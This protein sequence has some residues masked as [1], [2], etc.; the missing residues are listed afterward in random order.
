MARR[1]TLLAS[2]LIVA[3][4]GLGTAASLRDPLATQ[5]FVLLSAAVQAAA[6]LLVLEFLLDAARPRARA[7]GSPDR[8][9]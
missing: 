3:L 6:G 9:R 7:D 4:V 8:P 5:T 1:S 2:L